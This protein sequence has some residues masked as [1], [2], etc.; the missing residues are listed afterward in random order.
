MSTFII[1][2]AGVNHNGD[3]TLAKRLVEVAAGCGA[4]AVK[5]QSFSA[6]KLTAKGTQKA[7]Y[8]KR[9]TGNGDQYDMLKALEMSEHLHFELAKQCSSL[10]IEFMSTAFDE[11][12]LDML[13]AL[14][15][16][17]IKVPSGEITNHPF[18]RYM[19]AKNLPL[20][21][22]TGMADLAEVE[23]AIAVIADE[24]QKQGLP[25]GL[26]DIV[27]IL[28]CTSNYPAA[29]EDV[30]LNAMLTMG[31]ATG[32]P[33]GYSDHT[34]GTIVSTAAVAMG[35]CVI[36][37]HFTLD[38]SMTGPDH[39]AS[40]N[41]DELKAMVREIRTVEAAFGNGVK[42]PTASEIPVRALVRRSVTAVRSLPAG[43]VLEPVDIA[44][45]RPGTGIKPKDMQAILGRTTSRDIV[46]GQTLDWADLQ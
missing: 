24:R 45:M 40:L 1:A 35:A 32:M 16:R 5:F 42:M 37:K 14:G 30:N 25:D 19:A 34:I 43:T 36:E 8:Q 38:K 2:E 9:A 46:A 4:D 28:H 6:D 21:V 33:M 44:L 31:K 41:P 27:T 3:P 13:V 11:G 15:I 12:S 10:D 7:E 20:I 39:A 22:S 18:L 26:E 29:V 17:R 23:E